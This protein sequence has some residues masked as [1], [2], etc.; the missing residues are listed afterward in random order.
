MSL[1]SNQGSKKRKCNF[2]QVR[3]AKKD[4]LK[5]FTAWSC[6]CVFQELIAMYVSAVS[7]FKDDSGVHRGGVLLKAFV[8]RDVLIDPLKIRVVLLKKKDKKRKNRQPDFRHNPGQLF[9]L[10]N[11]FQVNIFPSF[12][13]QTTKT[14]QDKGW[15]SQKKNDYLHFVLET[16]LKLNWHNSQIW[17]IIN[18]FQY[19]AAGTCRCTISK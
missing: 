18:I 14:R 13:T 5:T 6:I 1:I 4:L 17:R 12:K 7:I 19:N 8:C 16:F 3:K 11:I 15:E 10:V 2:F 9:F